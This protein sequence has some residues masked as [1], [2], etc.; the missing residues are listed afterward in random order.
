MQ[1]I[2]L[3]L[4]F[5]HFLPVIRAASIFFW[6]GVGFGAACNKQSLVEGWGVPGH[7]VPG[8]SRG[9]LAATCV[10]GDCCS[11]AFLLMQKQFLETV[12]YFTQVPVPEL[13]L[14]VSPS[15]L[16]LLNSS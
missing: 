8:G 14:G 15:L 1:Q 16:Q 9:G 4:H 11:G 13:V 6:Q 12:F 5:M 7:L 3:L 2:S 10:M